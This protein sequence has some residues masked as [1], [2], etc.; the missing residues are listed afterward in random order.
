MNKVRETLSSAAQ[1]LTGPAAAIAAQYHALSA[2][3]ALAL[4][5]GAGL[6]TAYTQLAENRIREILDFIDAH[7]D[8]FVDSIVTSP[9]FIDVFINVWDLHIREAAENKRKRLRNFL[10]SVGSGEHI[11]QD[12]YTKVYSVIEQMTDQERQ[13]FLANSFMQAIGSSL[14]T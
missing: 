7:K 6:F 5:G 1:N 4:A 13:R 12:T 9:E 2:I 3:W 10:L 14:G 11:P 8:E